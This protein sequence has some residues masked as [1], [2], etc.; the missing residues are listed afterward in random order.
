MQ[1][2][3]S[4]QEAAALFRCD[5]DVTGLGGTLYLEG[6]AEGDAP[7]GVL[8][9]QPGWQLLRYACLTSRGETALLDI[10]IRDGAVAYW[11]MHT[12]EEGMQDDG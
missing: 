4:V 8:Q 3:Y 5:A 9:V 1:F 2:V 11:I 10:G 6:E 12:D 7:Y